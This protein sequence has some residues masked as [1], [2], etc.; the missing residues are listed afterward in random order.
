MVETS[1]GSS[2]MQVY[3]E[4]SHL[5]FR[6]QSLQGSRR[7]VDTISTET[8]LEI[9]HFIHQTSRVYLDACRRSQSTKQKGSLPIFR[10]KADF[11]WRWKTGSAVKTTV[12]S[13]R[14]PRF[15]SKY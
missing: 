6:D 4:F 2:S 13:C 7:H 10:I 15:N 3:R 5:G 1:I 12:C 11:I 14:G 8:I 9:T